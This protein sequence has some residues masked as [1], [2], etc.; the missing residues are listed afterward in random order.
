MIGPILG[1]AP[2]RASFDPAK[3]AMSTHGNSLLDPS[4]GNLILQLAAL[5]PISSR[6]SI[7][8]AAVAG[9]NWYDMIDYGSDF[10][11]STFQV[12]KENFLFLWETT[13]TI[14]SA[15]KT[16]RESCDAAVLCINR[17]K[18]VHPWRVILMTA[19]PRGDNLGTKYTAT[20][21]EVELQAANAYMRANYKAM[22]AEALVEVR[23][24]GGP[25][26]FTDSTNAANFP[27]SLWLDKTHP[28]NTG[29]G[30]IA[31]YVDDTLKRLRR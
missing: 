20:T 10:I 30:I 7:P 8:N 24:P 31:G 13:N 4:A 28:N 17:F 1:G 21:G 15:Q 9:F 27:A 23:R 2:P 12:G 18:N 16:G 19:L 5:P 6:F 3:Y 25:F 29:K 26:D 22:G 11:D 14:F